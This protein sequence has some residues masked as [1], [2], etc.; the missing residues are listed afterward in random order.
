MLLAIKADSY[1]L[2]NTD[3]TIDLRYCDV[4][5]VKIAPINNFKNRY[6]TL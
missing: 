1:L 3:K 4:V 5:R 2:S 6:G